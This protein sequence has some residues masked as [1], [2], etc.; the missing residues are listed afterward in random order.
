MISD[1]HIRNYL[2]KR[3]HQQAGLVEPFAFEADIEK[4]MDTEWSGTFETLMRKNLVMGAF[5][6]DTLSNNLKTG[7]R[8]KNIESAIARL[9]RYLKTGNQ[10]HLVDAANLCLIEFVIPGSHKDPYYHGIDEHNIHTEEVK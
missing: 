7:K 1:Q 8:H 3:L 6:H 10:E 9:K 2:R 5:R 4:L